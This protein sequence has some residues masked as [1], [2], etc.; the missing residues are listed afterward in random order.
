MIQKD[1]YDDDYD[2]D[3]DDDDG[4]DYDDDDDDD[5]LWSMIDT[6]VISYRFLPLLTILF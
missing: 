3:D 2:D 6:K 5:D 4:D 1:L